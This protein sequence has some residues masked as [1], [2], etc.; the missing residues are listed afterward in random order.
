MDYE[1]MRFECLK[2]AMSQ[3]FKGGEAILEADRLF[4]FIRDCIPS[5]EAAQPIPFKDYVHE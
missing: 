2:L 5:K 1:T 3:G 4:K